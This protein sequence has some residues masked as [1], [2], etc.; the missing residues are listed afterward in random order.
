MKTFIL[1]L[2]FVSTTI[3]AS[4]SKQ[5]KDTAACD[6]QAEAAGNAAVRKATVKHPLDVVKVKEE[7]RQK[8]FTACMAARAHPG[9]RAREK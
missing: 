8:E 6:K 9:S 3:F 5:D 7:A 1:L 4:E 2:A